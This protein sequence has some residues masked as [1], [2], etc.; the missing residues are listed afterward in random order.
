MAA[1]TIMRRMKHTAMAV[2]ASFFSHLP[3]G[4]EGII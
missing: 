3:G 1:H 2:P 4:C